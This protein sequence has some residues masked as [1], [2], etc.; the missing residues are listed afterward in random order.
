MKK[1]ILVP[2]DI[3]YFIERSIP[4]P[5]SGC[6][7]WLHA[8]NWKGYGQ[9]RYKG[10]NQSAHSLCYQLS[11]FSEIPFGSEVC[12]T[13]DNPSCVN[14]THLF[15]GTR[16]DNMKDCFKKGRSSL[17]V[18]QRGE[19]AAAA[20][21]TLSQVKSILLDTRS[22]RKIAKDYSVHRTTIT[23]IKSRGTWVSA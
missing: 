23:L 1:S 16:S 19:D 15:L 12:H 4:E 5:N 6:W 7:I 11:R 3:N 13:C 21:L 2:W 14:P 20:K 22:H 10:R 17:V 8:S 18:G 9:V